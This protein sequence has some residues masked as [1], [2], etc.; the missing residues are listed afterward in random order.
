MTRRKGPKPG[1]IR[2]PRLVYPV[3]TRLA[4]IYGM[5]LDREA[6]EG[7]PADRIGMPPADPGSA[8]VRPFS[9]VT[10]FAL[11]A[12]VT[13]AIL[14]LPRLR[15]RR[16]ASPAPVTSRYAD[17]RAAG[18][19]GAILAGW[20][21]RFVPAG[22]TDIHEVHDPVTSRSWLGF[23][24]PSAEGGRMTDQLTAVPA[25]RA[26]KVRVSG[27]DA[28]WWPP[29][30]R[31]TAGVAGLGTAMG[32]YLSPRRVAATGFREYV[33]VDWRSCRAFVWRE[34]R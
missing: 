24:F 25:E 26:G 28:A 15:P 7:R 10:V 21:P 34:S 5:D 3:G 19:A 33:A 17:L 32:L 29:E 13:C 6:R 23:R 14:Y 30:L 11:V 27:P 4:D 31:G 20:V 9:P 1:R 22:A 16:E 18:H 12:L 8:P 2:K